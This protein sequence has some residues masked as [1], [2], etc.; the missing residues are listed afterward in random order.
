L[1]GF[2]GRAPLQIGIGMISRGE[3]ALVI[4]GAG[5]AGGLVDQAIFS[6]LIVVTLATTL[7][8]PPLLRLAMGAHKAPRMASEP[9]PVLI[10]E[11]LA[12]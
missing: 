7:V 11:A 1:G 5:L 10:A 8:T 6:V 9:A 12:E 3:V 2:K 4:A